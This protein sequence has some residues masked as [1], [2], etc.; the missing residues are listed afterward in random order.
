MRVGVYSG[1]LTATAGGGFGFSEEIKNALLRVP[2]SH[3]FFIFSRQAPEDTETLATSNVRFVSLKR[4]VSEKMKSE[5]NKGAIK[6][7]RILPG[8]PKTL[9]KP[10]PPWLQTLAERYEIE[11][12][13][14]VTPSYTLVDIPFIFT[15][16]DLQHRR[17][18]WF[19]EVSSNGEWQVREELYRKALPRAA[20]VIVGTETGRDE[21]V[22][23]YRVPPDRVRSIRLP[24]PAFAVNPPGEVDSVVLEKYSL[25]KGYLFYPA[26]FWPHK[27]HVGLLL[28]LKVLKE[29]YRIS[30]TAVLVG[31]DHGNMEY[32]REMASKLG[33]AGQVRFLGFVPAED[34]PGLYRNALALVYLS[35]FGPDNLPPLEAFALGCPVIASRV[36]GA[37]EQLGDTALLVDGLNTEEVAQAVMRVYS[38]DELRRELI[39]KGLRRGASWTGEHYVKSVIGILDEFESVRRCWSPSKPYTP[40]S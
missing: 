23:F 3:D 27:N 37:E 24:T 19:P 25:D 11:L 13:W 28:S 39:G 32:V 22:H 20:A 16:L 15:V 29:K 8:I 35:L 21:I 2:G 10:R 34:L 38:E 12:M 31:S 26:Q 1:D 36:T 14:F 30:L 4:D 40:K 6:L 17:Q 9:R 18:P 33:I 5:F 7:G